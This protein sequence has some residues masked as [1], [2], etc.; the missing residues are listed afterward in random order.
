[1]NTTKKDRKQK[2]IRLTALVVA[3][4]MVVTVVLAVLLQ[5]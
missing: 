3:V 4:V 2:W 1:M 5:P